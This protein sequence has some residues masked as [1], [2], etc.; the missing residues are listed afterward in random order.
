MVE[1][2]EDRAPLAARHL[3]NRCREGTTDALKSVVVHRLLP[4]SAIFLG[5]SN[6]CAF[7]PYM[8]DLQH[9]HISHSEVTKVKLAACIRFCRTG[10]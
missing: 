2:F 3:L 7:P 5:T 1:V 6:G 8:Q 4:D 10:A 9:C